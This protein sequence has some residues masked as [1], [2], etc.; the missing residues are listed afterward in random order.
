M[1]SNLHQN[2]FMRLNIAALILFLFTRFSYATV[3]T[4]SDCTADAQSIAEH[5]STVGFNCNFSN[6]ISRQRGYRCQIKTATYSM[7]VDIF[8][9]PSFQ[10]NQPLAV[11]YH[12][13]GF[14]ID[15]SSTPFDGAD[16]D[17]G[18]F[19]ASSR[20]NIILIIPESRGK[21]AS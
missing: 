15:P 11:A 20:K 3:S 18:A 10:K 21:D 2:L 7:P 1:R 14:W 5:L 4:C 6:V 16:G 12:L 9:A 8:I 19:V 17:F 13:H